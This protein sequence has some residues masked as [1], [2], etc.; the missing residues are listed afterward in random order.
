VISYIRSP[1]AGP[2]DATLSNKMI[3]FAERRLLTALSATC[4]SNARTRTRCVGRALA[5]EASAANVFDRNTKRLQR[6][7]AALAPDSHDYDYLKN[8]MAER[9]ADR[10]LVSSAV[11]TSIARIRSRRRTLKTGNSSQFWTWVQAVAYCSSI[12]KI[13]V[14][15][16]QRINWK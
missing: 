16:K 9:L 3:T 4:S 14:V 12:C 2:H 7:R 10:V 1:I 5:T 6:S 8:E 11:Q 15:Q 13:N